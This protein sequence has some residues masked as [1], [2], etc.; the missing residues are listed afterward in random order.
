MDLLR[1]AIA[2]KEAGRIIVGASSL[3]LRARKEDVANPEDD[4]CD[5][6]SEAIGHGDHTSFR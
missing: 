2:G 4:D 1:D 5:C 3:S 6:Y